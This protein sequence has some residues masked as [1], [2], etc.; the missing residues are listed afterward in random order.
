MQILWYNENFLNNANNCFNITWIFVSTCSLKEV[1]DQNKGE[2]RQE[3]GDG[4]RED[5]HPGHNRL[6]A[7]DALMGIRWAG[8]CYKNTC[9][10]YIYF[11]Q[12]FS[13]SLRSSFCSCSQWNVWK[14]GAETVMF[15]FFLN[16]SNTWN[17]N[18]EN[19]KN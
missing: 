7:R 11:F 16:E 5:Q 9:G 14:C 3:D 2:C 10:L 4:W 17:W 19:L 18:L 13:F 6:R 8:I 1:I 12:F 15:I